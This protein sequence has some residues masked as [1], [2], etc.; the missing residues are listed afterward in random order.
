MK[1]E[2]NLVFVYGTLKNGFG[3]HCLLEDSKFYADA[4]AYGV[5][6]G[7]GRPFP[8]AFF[9]RCEEE[10]DTVLCGKIIYGEVY[11]VSK[12]IIENNLDLLEGFCP[13]NPEISNYLRKE[14]NVFMG[15]ERIRAFAYEANMPLERFAGEKPIKLF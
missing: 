3:N 2:G 5:M 8:Y 11:S 9:D 1:E 7:K 15:N 10:G 6:F 13:E 4:Y 12:D 14:I